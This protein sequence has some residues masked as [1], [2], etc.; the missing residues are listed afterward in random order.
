MTKTSIP[1]SNYLQPYLFLPPRIRNTQFYGLRSL[2]IGLP[3][4]DCSLITLNKVLSFS[5]IT[6]IPPPHLSLSDYRVLTMSG[7][8]YNSF[9]FSLYLLNQILII[10]NR[11]VSLNRLNFSKVNFFKK[12][13][14]GGRGKK[15][16][17]SLSRVYFLFIF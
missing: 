9:F 4:Q 13:K 7:L 14:G 5:I 8:S 11:G 12:K 16:R 17:V 3:S 2:P 6:M 10:I 15:W 1:P